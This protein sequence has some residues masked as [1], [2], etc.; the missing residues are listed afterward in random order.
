MY[1]SG[2]PHDD[3]F[4]VHPENLMALAGCI[5]AQEDIPGFETAFGTVTYFH[6]KLAFNQND[7]LLLGKAMPL[8]FMATFMVPDKHFRRFQGFGLP[9]DAWLVFN[10]NFSFSKVRLPIRSCVNAG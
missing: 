6:F 10:G 1:V 4:P 7:Q 5:F 8:G 9:A 2:Q 3:R